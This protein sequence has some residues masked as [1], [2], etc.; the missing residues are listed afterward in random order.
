MPVPFFDHTGFRR[1]RQLVDSGDDEFFLFEG[2]N[3]DTD[4]QRWFERAA[5]YAGKT[6]RKRRSS[7]Q[8]HG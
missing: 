7:W 5:S 2:L 3:I 1:E 6:G 4:L 8:R